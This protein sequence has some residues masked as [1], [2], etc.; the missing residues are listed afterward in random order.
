MLFIFGF[1]VSNIPPPLLTLVKTTGI[2]RHKSRHIREHKKFPHLSSSP[3]VA[4]E[5]TGNGAYPVGGSQDRDVE[6][7]EDTRQV[8]R[9]STTEESVP[10][11]FDHYYRS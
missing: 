9:L 3:G 6:V 11:F 8:P 5:G 2:S 7:D 1:P 10:F 4:P